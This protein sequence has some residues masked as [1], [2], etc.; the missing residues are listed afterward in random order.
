MRIVGWLWYENMVVA[1]DEVMRP[2]VRHHLCSWQDLRVELILQFAELLLV[3][4]ER[5]AK[6]EVRMLHGELTLAS[7]FISMV[8]GVI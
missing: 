1:F 6:V 2:N 4:C 3:T 7:A 5:K 8:A